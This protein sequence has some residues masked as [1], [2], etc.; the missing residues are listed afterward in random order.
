MEKYNRWRISVA[1]RECFLAGIWTLG[2]HVKRRSWK[3]KERDTFASPTLQQTIQKQ[4]NF[5]R[6]ILFFNHSIYFFFITAVCLS[7][8]FRTTAV[9]HSHHMSHI[10]PFPCIRIL[11]ILRNSKSACSLFRRLRVLHTVTKSRINTLLQR[12]CRNLGV[13]RMAAWRLGNFM[14]PTPF[15]SQFQLVLNCA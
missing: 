8:L 11:Q 6:L 12:D 1:G 7:L 9:S 5:L 13:C 3:R 15:G 14:P 2:K 10:Q 4:K